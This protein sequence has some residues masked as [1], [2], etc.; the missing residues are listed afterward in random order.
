MDVV[1]ITQKHNIENLFKQMIIKFEDEYQRDFTN[2]FED[3][4][5]QLAKG[6]IYAMGL[7]SNNEVLGYLEYERVSVNKAAFYIIFVGKG[8]NKVA[9]ISN[10]FKKSM[11]ILNQEGVTSF[12]CHIS[13]L[14]GIP[15]KRVMSK[16]DF[17]GYKRYE[18]ALELKKVKDIPSD[19]KLRPYD[20]DII[21][22][23]KKLMR[24]AF[25]GSIDGVL[26]SEFFTI[27][28]QEKMIKQ[29]S[30]GYYGPFLMEQSQLM[31]DESKLM[32]YALLTAKGLGTAF[33]MDFA[34]DPEYQGRGLS[35]V[36]LNRIIN[37]LVSCQYKTLKLAVTGDNK[38]AYKLY[39][40]I[41]FK[42]LNQFVIYHC[43]YQV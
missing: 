16:I 10:F 20:S 34:I 37:K 27:E 7:V 43:D 35:K 23:L 25:E 26:Y 41:G 39:K 21:D 22:D 28:G 2:L 6:S 29:I 12:V 15:L 9:L 24:K 5:K 31:Y 30:N 4:K 19:F 40:K 33:I 13:P 17:Q 32:G 36:L 18:M 11:E 1:K 3:K 38:K 42:V 14:R 8:L